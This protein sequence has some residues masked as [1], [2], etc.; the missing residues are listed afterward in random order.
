[1]AQT[2]STHR[3]SSFFS[4]AGAPHRPAIW[5]VTAQNVRAGRKIWLIPTRSDDRV[6]L[7]GIKFFA[8]P[9]NLR[10]TPNLLVASSI[11]QSQGKL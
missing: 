5:R 10:Q 9:H 3:S 2:R 1:H 11:Q 6:V 8:Q 4:I 7:E